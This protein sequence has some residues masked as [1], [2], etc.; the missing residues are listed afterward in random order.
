MAKGA[1][2]LLLVCIA[3][4]FGIVNGQP[5][6]SLTYY[7]TS[8]PQVST[9]VDQIILAAIQQSKNVVG[10]LLRLHFHDCFVRGCEA[11][12][13]LDSIP[14]HFAEKDGPGNANSLRGFDVIDN[15]KNALEAACPG[16]V[17]CA[18]I[19]ALVAQSAISQI[20]GPSWVVPLGRRDGTISNAA[21]T[22]SN[23]PSFTASYPALKSIFA[24]KGLD[25]QDMVALSGAHTVGDTHCN[26]IE[27]RLYNSTGPGGVDPT[28]DATYAAQLKVQCPYSNGVSMTVIP[29]DPTLGGNTFDSNY[30]GNV[31]AHKGLFISDETLLSNQVGAKYVLQDSSGPQVPFFNDFAAAMTK[32]GSVTV[33]LA[34]QG[35]IR[36]NCHFVNP[37]SNAST[38]TPAAAGP[39]PSVTTTSP[40][41][42]PSPVATPTPT[43]TAVPAAAPIVT[44][45][46][47]TPTAAPAP[48]PATTPTPAPVTTTATPPTAAP[49]AVPTAVPVPTPAPTK[50][51]TTPTAAPVPST[52]AS[53]PTTVPTTAPTT[54]PATAPTA[55][56]P[57]PTAIS[58]APTVTSTVPAPTAKS[59]T[60]APVPAPVASP[61]ISTATSS[62]TVD[63]SMAPAPA[64][65]HKKVKSSSS[66][67]SPSPIYYIVVRAAEVVIRMLH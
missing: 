47:A 54:T 46:T 13:L 61:P 16:V 1:A 48:P 28:L 55:T 60:T 57:A 34:P 45:P 21:D 10:G 26:K 5:S 6:M 58:P 18:D 14:P 56:S 30:Y 32:M 37:S 23:L 36:Q 7:S 43:P 15:V 63:K 20:G 11:S 25:E 9:I 4:V 52:A 53:V 27:P 33:L 42:A 40:V 59:P 50:A 17:S 49:V 3:G 19:L 64:P 24:S 8:C 29:M 38:P 35:E 41:S 12:V 67:I 39:A 65:S 22:S 51:S 31:L 66:R 44:P 62:S 2:L